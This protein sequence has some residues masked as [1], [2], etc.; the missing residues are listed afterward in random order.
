[1]SCQFK[2]S[3]V[4]TGT[5]EFAQTFAASASLFAKYQIALHNIKP[6]EC[7]LEEYHKFLVDSPIQV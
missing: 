3:L 6:N 4:R 2:V 7:N 1:M 5:K